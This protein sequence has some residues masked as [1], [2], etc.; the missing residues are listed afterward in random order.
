MRTVFLGLALGAATLLPSGRAAAPGQRVPEGRYRLAV[1]DGGPSAFEARA[2]IFSNPGGSGRVVLRQ[3]AVRD[4]ACEWLTSEEVRLR[5]TSEGWQLTF[6][7]GTESLLRRVPGTH[8]RWESQVHRG[9]S[10]GR[11]R[12]WIPLRG[13]SRLKREFADTCGELSLRTSR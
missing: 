6:A 12:T 10:A 4:A 7:D 2:E 13:P 3:G 9:P 1:S 5:P 8:D 11:R